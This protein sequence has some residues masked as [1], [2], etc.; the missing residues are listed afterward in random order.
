MIK[1]HLYTKLFNRIPQNARVAIFGACSL[2]SEIYKDILINRKDVIVN[3]FIDNNKE[4]VFRDLPILKLQDIVNQ[5]ANYDMEKQNKMKEDEN[6]LK[7][8]KKYLQYS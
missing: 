2:G 5:K 6:K 4:G 1:E 8:Q 7:E 3:C